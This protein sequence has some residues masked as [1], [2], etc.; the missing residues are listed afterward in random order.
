MSDGFGIKEHNTVVLSYS[1][2]KH[3]ITIVLVGDFFAIP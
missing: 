1:P 3:G 2:V